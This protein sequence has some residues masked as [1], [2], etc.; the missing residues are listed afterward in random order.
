MFVLG[1]FL[2][3]MESREHDTEEGITEAKVANNK[4][5]CT[6]LLALVSLD[7]GLGGGRRHWVPTACLSLK[8][9]CLQNYSTVPATSRRSRR[10]PR[11][12]RT[13]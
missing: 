2:R 7:W 9:Q 6:R 11:A 13:P 3:C 12:S 8:V 4:K 10:G 5:S 1:G